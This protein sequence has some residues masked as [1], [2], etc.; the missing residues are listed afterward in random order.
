MNEAYTVL[1]FW[2][3]RETLQLEL[4]HPCF[5]PLPSLFSCPFSIL[6]VATGDIWICLSSP[7]FFLR[8]RLTFIEL[9]NFIIQR[10]IFRGWYPS[11]VVKL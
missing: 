3:E 5:S 9:K 2:L 1:T 6:I 7:F 4:A 10:A 11:A 8:L